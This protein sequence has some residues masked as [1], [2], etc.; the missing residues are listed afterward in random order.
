MSKIETGEFTLFSFDS[1]DKLSV[2][3][4]ASHLSGHTLRELTD[5][6]ESPIT[7][8]HTKGEFGTLV[9]ELYFDYKPNNRAEPD[10]PEINVELKTTKLV[11]K[12]TLGWDPGERLVL[13]V[14]NYENVHPDCFSEVF[15]RKNSELL[16]IFYRYGPGSLLDRVIDKVI[17]WTFSP[18]EIAVMKEDWQ[19]AEKLILCGEAHHLT[20]GGTMILTWPPKGAGGSKDLRNQPFST[21]PARQRALALKNSYVCKMYRQSLDLGRAISEGV[22]CRLWDVPDV[23]NIFNKMWDENMSFE[24]AIVF[25]LSRYI[26]MSCDDIEAATEKL[27]RSAKSY[28]A[29]LANRMLGVKKEHAA[30]IDDYD[31]QVKIIRLK[32]N[33]KCKESMSF[34]AF[35]Y[36]R[37]CSIHGRMEFHE[38]FTKRFLFI[39]FQMTDEK[40][41]DFGNAVYRGSFFWS[42]PRRDW[43]EVSFVYRD[44]VNQIEKNIYDDFQRMSN[45]YVIHVRPHAR[46][47]NDTSMCPDG[48]ARP[49]KS[50]W[51]NADY[52]SKVVNDNLEIPLLSSNIQ[53]SRKVGK[54]RVL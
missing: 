6:T 31:I 36:Q 2:L 4:Y 17:F 25:R 8:I 39:V 38:T 15:E 9:E 18:Q 44:T 10:F 51:F 23:E 1:K 47:N 32:R 11:L 29:L 49:K 40:D 14:I 35:D 7:S 26:G 53:S 50:F 54:R 20:E 48:I 12:K 21:R 27:N 13:N 5:Y 37:L 3:R 43:A 30:E 33:R 41:S 22:P 42:L 34:P 24:D 16:V 52:I 28:Y 19:K 45:T 46:D